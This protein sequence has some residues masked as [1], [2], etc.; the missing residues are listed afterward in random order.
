M[1]LFRLLASYET[2]MMSTAPLFSVENQTRNVSK[3]R[4]IRWLAL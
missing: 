2:A 1:R 4:W 3:V